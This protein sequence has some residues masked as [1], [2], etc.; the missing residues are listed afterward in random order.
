L[1]GTDLFTNIAR[2]WDPKGSN[3]GRVMLNSAI[4]AVT[5]TVLAVL[6]CS[7]AG[8]AFAKFSFRG[9]NILFFMFLATLM[10][11]ATVTYVPL[12]KMMAGWHWLNTYQAVILPTVASPFGIF[13]MRQSMSLLP[14]ELMEAAR[15][16]GAGEV[17][18]FWR[19]ALPV[20]GPSLAALSIFMFMSQWN[21]FF[22]PLVVMQKPDM[23][24]I[25]VSISS[26]IGFSIV[27]YGAIMTGTTLAVLPLI[28]LFLSMQRQFISG[29]LAGSVKG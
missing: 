1:P 26:Q 27:D 21:N 10:I 5:Y 29:A 22:W 17:G 12:Y 13:L 6:V 8:Y 25:P 11:P 24:T 18:I 14:T 16:D 2:L 4:I 7:L 19:V 9:R 15:I 20:M 3:F 23:Q 28:I